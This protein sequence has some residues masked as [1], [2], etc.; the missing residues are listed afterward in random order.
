MI[1]INHEHCD[2]EFDEE[3]AIYQIHVDHRKCKNFTKEDYWKYKHNFD[4]E[5]EESKKVID[6]VNCMKLEK[7][8]LKFHFHF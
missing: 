1:S 8:C 3:K 7:R 6:L 5:T 4:N 2:T